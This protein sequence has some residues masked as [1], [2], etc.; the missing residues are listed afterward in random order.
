ME[1]WTLVGGT[2]ADGSGSEPARADVVIEDGRIREISAP[3]SRQRDGTVLDISGLVVTPGFIDMH[4]HSDLAVLADPEHL[5]KSMQGVTME[6]VGQDGLGYSPVNDEVMDL[7]KSQIAGWNGTPHLDYSWRTVGEYLDRVD[8]GSAVNVATLVPHGTVRMMVMGSAARPASE[9]EL[10]EI[11]EIVGHAMQ[12]GAMGLSTGLTYVPG[13]YASDAEIVDVL[14]EVRTR[15]GFYCSHHRNYGVGVVEAYKACL[16][17]AERAQVPLHLAHCHVNFP[18][19]RGRA[20]EV[21][22][23]I[24]SAAARGLDVTL[25]SY[26]YLAGATYLAALLPSWTQEHGS[27]HT[28]G[29]LS[30]PDSRRRILLE[31]ENSGSD[32]HHGV[33]M[34]WEVIRVSSVGDKAQAWSVGKSIS[35]LARAANQPAG[36]LFAQLLI[37]DRLGTGCLVEVGNEE[38]VRAIMGHAS[39]TVGSDG[40][41]VGERPHPRGWGTFPRFL[42]TYVREAG[43]MSF[44]EG[45]AHLTSRAAR[46][47]GLRDRGLVHPGFHADLVVLDPASVGSAASYED[48][49]V[50]P[51]GITHVFVNGAPT[52]LDGRRTDRSPGRSVRHPSMQ[53]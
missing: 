36:E 30:D 23:A 37:S 28:I 49:K 50:A 52:V 17:L 47:L 19:N 1:T 31:M 24:D 3:S 26:P 21:I 25:D 39:H 14:E 9:R 43:V 20:A 35:E 11:R 29:L 8:A 33:P 15:G 48:P 16:A 12:D 6:V 22:A 2:V 45:I 5:A 32:G 27:G 13:M 46:R 7:T 44:S 38:N 41:L 40:I 10:T 34:D 51:T 53:V 42:G 18:Q 4:A